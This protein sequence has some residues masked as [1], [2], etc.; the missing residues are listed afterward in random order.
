MRVDLADRDPADRMK[1]AVLACEEECRRPLDLLSGPILRLTLYRLSAADHV[2]LMTVHHI[3]FDGWSLGVFLKELVSLYT[4]FSE[5]R[6]SP[7]PDL[8]VR[9]S[10]FALSQ[11]QGLQ[12]EVLDKLL[13][14]WRT[15]LDGSRPTWRCRL[16]IPLSPA[17]ITGAAGIRWCWTRS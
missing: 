2:L 3:V 11:R 4:A 8:P 14:F 12:G 15:N 13:A 16:T 9:H 5:G 6:P 1:Q 10:E 17:G 7:L